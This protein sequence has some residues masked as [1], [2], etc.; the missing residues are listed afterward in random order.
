MNIVSKVCAVMTAG[1]LAVGTLAGCSSSDSLVAATVNGEEILESKVTSYVESFR[2]SYDLED[3]EDW[4]EWMEEND[5][6]AEDIRQIAIDYYTEFL[7][8]GQAAEDNGVSVSDEEVDEAIQEMRSYYGM[9]DDDDWADLLEE[10]GYTEDDYWEEM[11]YSLLSE[12]LQAVVI[13]DVDEATD[14]EILEYANMYSTYLD[15]YQDIDVI[16]CED[17]DTATDLLSQITNGDLTFDE[18]KEQNAGST[19]YDGITSMISVDTAISTE[20]ADMEDG[21][22][23]SVVASE[24]IDG[25]YYIIRVNETI[26]VPTVDEDSDE[27]PWASI[28]DVPEVVYEAMADYVYDANVY[29]AFI[30]YLEELEDSAEIVINDMPEGLSYDVEISSNSSDDEESEDTTED[31]EDEEDGATVVYADEEE[32]TS[33]EDTEDS[34]EEDATE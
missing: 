9:E 3:D 6:T 11:Y 5:Y 7:L 28:D 21:S 27:D 10:N 1:A 34:T 14:D 4:A 25:E 24:D 20:I 31:S 23:S 17:E 26:E 30:E 12:A 13:T 29:I 33:D 22:I 18:A 16:V 15:G 2:V 19:D 32:D 8:L